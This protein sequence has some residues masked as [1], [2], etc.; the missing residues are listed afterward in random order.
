MARHGMCELTR[1]GMAWHGRGTAWVR[2]GMC[3]LAFADTDEWELFRHFSNWVHYFWLSRSDVILQSPALYV[4]ACYFH[5]QDQSL[6][7]Y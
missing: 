2:H 1:H 4:T 7:F 6:L 5:I 3:E